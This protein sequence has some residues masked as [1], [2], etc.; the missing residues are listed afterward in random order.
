MAR[1]ENL[2]GKTVRMLRLP[3]LADELPGREPQRLLGLVV[4]LR[5]GRLVDGYLGDDAARN[6]VDLDA[7]AD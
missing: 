1:R 5:P 3:A 2:M 7:P 6:R 4:D